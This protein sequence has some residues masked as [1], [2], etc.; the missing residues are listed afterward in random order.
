VGSGWW[1][2]DY[3]SVGDLNAHLLRLG[4]GVGVIER[5]DLGGIDRGDHFP[6][7]LPL[8]IAGSDGAPAQAVLW[9]VTR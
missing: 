4:A 6:I 1:G 9:P 8:N 3:L 7:C 5:L 2:I